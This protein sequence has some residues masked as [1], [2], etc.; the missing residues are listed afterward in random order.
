MKVTKEQAQ[1]MWCPAMGLEQY[2]SANSCMLWVE[3]GDKGCCGYSQETRH[4][5]YELEKR[6]ANKKAEGNPLGRTTL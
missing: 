3:L 5:L 2:C 4:E 1:I 6:K